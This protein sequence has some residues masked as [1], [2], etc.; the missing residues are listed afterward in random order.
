ML[1]VLSTETTVRR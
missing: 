1:I